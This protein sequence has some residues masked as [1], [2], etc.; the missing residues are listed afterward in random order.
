MKRTAFA[1]LALMG[2]AACD[3][4]KKVSADLLDPI[5]SGAV[6]AVV[7][8][9]AEYGKD[10]VLFRLHVGA[11]DVEVGAYQ[12]RLTFNPAALEVLDIRPLT[13]DGEFRIVNKDSVAAGSIPF[14]AF[15]SEAFSSTVVFDLVVRPIL[16]LQT[17]NL[18]AQLAVVGETSGVA[19]EARRLRLN[20]GVR[21][22]RTNAL[23]LPGA[24]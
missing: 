12:G 19:V 14:A 3:D 2:V 5:P 20:D 6:Q 21:D 17:A 13:V 11:K 18:V 23:I 8:R 10:S 1:L 15:T 7:Q 16:D 9:V 4:E 22:A 24:R